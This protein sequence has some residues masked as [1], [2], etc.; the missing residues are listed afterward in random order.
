MTRAQFVA[1]L[2][3]FL[4]ARLALPGTSVQPHTRL[5]AAGLLDSLRILELI[6]WTE[7]ALGQRIP[8]ERI[9]M[10]YFWSPARIA[11]VFIPEAGHA[12]S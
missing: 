2:V 5:F 11:E 4:N 7:R 6:A 8:D 10:D 9:R 3:A 1:D 12:G